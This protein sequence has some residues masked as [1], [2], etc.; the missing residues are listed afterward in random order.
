MPSPRAV[1]GASV[2]VPAGIGPS[3]NSVSGPLAD[4]EGV[5]VGVAGLADDSEV[6]D[7]L[8][9]DP[10]L[11]SPG[12]RR[13]PTNATNTTAARPTLGDRRRCITGAEFDCGS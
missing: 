5:G 13:K 7:G 10:M 3:G 12:S 9:T 1:N 6:V 4:G 8:G 2:Y 11:P